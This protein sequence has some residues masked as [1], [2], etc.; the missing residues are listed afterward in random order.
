MTSTRVRPTSPPS[1]H[2]T[3]EA[4][5]EGF[6]GHRVTLKKRY[7]LLLTQ[8]SAC[9]IIDTEWKVADWKQRTRR[10]WGNSSYVDCKV[11]RRPSIE[12]FHGALYH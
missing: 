12:T 3:R 11:S 4:D 1:I 5:R 2:E 7:G 10:C 9:M 8:N 6:A